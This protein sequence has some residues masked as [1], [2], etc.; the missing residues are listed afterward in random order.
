[1]IRINVAYPIVPMLP[2][3][4]RHFIDRGD[5]YLVY[6]FEELRLVRSPNREVK[7]PCWIRRFFGRRQNVKRFL[8]RALNRNRKIRSGFHTHHRCCGGRLGCVR[9][10]HV[11]TLRKQH[12]G[13]MDRID[14]C[15]KRAPRRGCT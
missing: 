14:G 8:E 7:T 6:G 1:M 15:R 10:D 13:A 9:Q 11:I 3:E 2:E 5:E 4:T 12:H